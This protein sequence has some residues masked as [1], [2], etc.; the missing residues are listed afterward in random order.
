MVQVVISSRPTAGQST[1][2]PLKNPVRLLL[3]IKVPGIGGID[4]GEDEEIC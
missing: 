1:V 3:T 4:I 2:C